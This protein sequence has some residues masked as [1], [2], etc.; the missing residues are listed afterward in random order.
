MNDPTT[1]AYV[2]IGVGMLLLLAELLIPT[3]GIMFVAGGIVAVIGVLLVFVY[4]SWQN[5]LVTLAVV[6]VGLPVVITVGLAVYPRTPMGKRLMQDG[7][8][9]EE[10]LAALPVFQE[11][12]ALKGRIGK[13]ISSLRPAGLVE[14]DGKRVDCFSEGIMIDPGKWVKC[15]EVKSGGKVIVRVVEQPQEIAEFDS[16]ELK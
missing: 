8:A 16:F 13:T 12:E 14:F 3:G 2:L 5:G 7:D 15:V 11:L 6:S 9:S 1:I 4:G 10:T